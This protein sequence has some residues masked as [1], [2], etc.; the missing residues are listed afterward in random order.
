MLQGDAPSRKYKNVLITKKYVL[1]SQEKELFYL[2]FGRCCE[3]INDKFEVVL[4]KETLR[5]WQA[6]KTQDP[7]GD[8]G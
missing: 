6:K 7:G 5:K 8:P 4:R 1:S 2:G 3:E